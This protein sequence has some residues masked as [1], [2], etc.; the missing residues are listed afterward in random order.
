MLQEN[1]R[2]IIRYT[3]KF[4]IKRFNAI[5]QFVPK[6]MW[7]RQHKSAGSYNTQYLKP[8]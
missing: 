4:I 3:E 8:I 5:L 2:L 1:A 7:S 6:T